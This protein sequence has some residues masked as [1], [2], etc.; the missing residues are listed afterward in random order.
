[1]LELWLRRSG[2]L[3]TVLCVVAVSGGPDL[4]EGALVPFLG[5]VVLFGTPQYF[6]RKRTIVEPP[7]GA[8]A[9]S[10]LV[11]FVTITLCLPSA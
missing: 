2:L 6:L 10:R 1:M 8:L 5:D 7:L 9:V 3:V 11:C 4:P